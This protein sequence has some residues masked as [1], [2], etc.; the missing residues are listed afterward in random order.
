ME[1][2]VKTGFLKPSVILQSWP[3]PYL[4]IPCLFLKT[5]ILS[6]HILNHYLLPPNPRFHAQWPELGNNLFSLSNSSWSFLL[7][8]SFISFTF[9]ISPRTGSAKIWTCLSTC[10]IYFH[11][12]TGLLSRSCSP[13]QA[14]ELLVHSTHFLIQRNKVWRSYRCC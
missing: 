1:V 7:H 2:E 5:L 13:Q 14:R 9:K 8:P 6:V 10:Y 11:R 12:A 4:G 3:A